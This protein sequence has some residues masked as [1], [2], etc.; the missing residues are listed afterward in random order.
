MEQVQQQGDKPMPSKRVLAI[1]FITHP[2]KPEQ[3][4][5]ITKTPFT[6]GRGVEDNEFPFP[7]EELRISRRH[8][9]LIFDPPYIILTDLESSNGTF[10]NEQRL[11]PGQPCY[12]FFGDEFNID[13]YTLR[14]AEAT[15]AEVHDSELEVRSIHHE[16]TARDTLRPT[17]SAEGSPPPPP[18]PPASQEVLPLPE[19]FRVF[20][21]SHPSRYLQYLPPIYHD[22]PFLDMF[23]QG[24][25]TVLTPI[26]Q[27]V[28]NFDLYLDPLVT[29]AFFLDQL[30]A[31]VNITLDER[32]SEIE[33]RKLLARIGFI[34]KWRGTKKGLGEH[35]KMFYPDVTLEIIEPTTQP[36]YFE[37]TVHIPPNHPP[38]DKAKVDHIIEEHKPAHTTYRSQ[39]VVS[40]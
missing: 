35:I 25:E 6:I 11:E 28:D 15:T 7:E 10:I 31:W 16:G 36:H 1:L 3:V 5:E 21:V 23:L 39:V 2:D 40:Q 19:Y 33:R 17:V 27:K 9:Q 18:S 24:L 29:P 12:I 22:E 13:A 4:I 30:A 34:Q 26:E 38:V 14:L 32:W 8:A 20:G 37:V